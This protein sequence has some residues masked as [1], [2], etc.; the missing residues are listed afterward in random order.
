MH[1]SVITHEAYDS[2]TTRH[3]IWRTR[4]TAV[5]DTRVRPSDTAY[6]IMTHQ[7]M[8]VLPKWR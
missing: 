2:C 3:L 8:T 7:P 4:L 6:Y 5:S 1:E